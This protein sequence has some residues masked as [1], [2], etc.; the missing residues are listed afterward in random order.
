MYREPTYHV[1]SEVR[2]RERTLHTTEALRTAVAKRPRTRA[3]IA[4][5]RLGTGGV[6]TVRALDAALALVS[7]EYAGVGMVPEE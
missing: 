3:H 7:V 6:R 4:H 1:P 2:P 5:L